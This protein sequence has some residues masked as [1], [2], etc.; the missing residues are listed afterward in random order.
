MPPKQAEATRAEYNVLKALW[1][2][3]HGTVAEVK[4]VC[5]ESSGV[6]LAYTTVMTLL[7][8]L[9]AKRLVKVDKTRAVAG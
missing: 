1:R 7:R 6:E 9:E 4:Q 5:T 2:L 8:R 3:K